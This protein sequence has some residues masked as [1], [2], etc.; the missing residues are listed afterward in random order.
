MQV[1]YFEELYKIPGLLH[2]NPLRLFLYI[3]FINKKW[4]FRI[5]YF[6]RYDVKE[7]I[8]ML[9]FIIHGDF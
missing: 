8:Q 7:R 9:I 3:V 1:W 6:C 4:I 2:F 5:L